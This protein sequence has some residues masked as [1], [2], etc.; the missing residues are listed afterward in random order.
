MKKSVVLALVICLGCVGA[1]M[2]GG[3][4]PVVASFVDDFVI[5]AP[6]QAYHGNMID[7]TPRIGVPGV[8]ND[9]LYGYADAPMVEGYQVLTDTATFVAFNSCLA[10][11]DSAN[12]GFYG[13]PVYLNVPLMT[14]SLPCVWW[15]AYDIYG[16]YGSSP[17]LAGDGKYVAIHPGGA[18]DMDYYAG[19]VRWTSDM[20]GTVDIDGLFGVGGTGDRRFQIFKNGTE[21][22]YDETYAGMD[23]IIALSGISVAAGTTIDFCV[24]QETAISNDGTPLIA[25][26][27]IP[28]PVSMLLLG[29]GSVA[30]L[31][32]RK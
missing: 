30:L 11:T 20:A 15:N 28:E 23:A 2:A 9:W 25:N 7:W 5:N 24:T 4:D 29:L 22:I 32:R 21:L 17:Q 1:S 16:L 27:T 12:A 3:G 26:I 18:L 31:R 10:N 8:D 19:V 14:Y 13:D 6:W